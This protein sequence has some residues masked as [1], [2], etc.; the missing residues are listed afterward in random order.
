[1]TDTINKLKERAVFRLKAFGQVPSRLYDE[2]DYVNDHGGA[3][4]LLLLSD[5][6]RHLKS[7][8]IYVGPGY[9]YS[10]CS[11]L[12]YGLGITDIESVRWGLPFEHFTNSFNQDNEFWIETSTGGF[13]KTVEFLNHRC[14][15]PISIVPEKNHVIDIVLLDDQQFSNLHLAITHNINLDIIKAL[16]A[17]RTIKPSKIEL[18]KKSLDFFR[19][20]DTN[21]IYGFAGQEHQHLLKEFQPECFSDICLF[22]TLYRHIRHN[23]TLDMILEIQRRKR[24]NDIPATGIP[25][26]DSILM[27]SYGALVYRE[28]AI[29][30]KQVLRSMDDDERVTAVKKMLDIPG[31]ILYPK[32]H[33]ISR[34]MMSVEL[35][36]YKA[37]IPYRYK[38]IQR[39]VRIEAIKTARER[40][41]KRTESQNQE[42]N[43]NSIK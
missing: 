43:I 36:Y 22:E 9:G 4:A 18:D 23:G 6:V 41:R 3:D 32:G 30:I 2:L 40:I 38:V 16:S 10:T 27:E 8:N 39:I 21:D 11:L 1:M 37:R 33:A 29:R 5:L 34:T 19:D 28:Q 14:E 31:V 24:E 13:E 26:V 42:S 12:C 7:E 17:E 15:Y 35:A 25:E 20:G